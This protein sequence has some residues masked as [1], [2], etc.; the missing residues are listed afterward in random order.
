MGLTGALLRAGAARPHVLIAAVPGGTAVRLAAEATLRRRGWP[1]ALTPA[2]AD[3]L[4]IAGT[5]PPDFPGVLGAVLE[6]LP[7]PPA[8]GQAAAA[9][10]GPALPG[11]PPG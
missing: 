11:A 1:Q 4:L 9:G 2:G 5:G 7:A 8:P 3:P 6:G 10:R